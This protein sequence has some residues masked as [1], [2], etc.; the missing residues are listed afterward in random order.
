[1]TTTVRDATVED[2]TVQNATAQDVTVQVPVESMYPILAVL[3]QL[4][5]LHHVVPDWTRKS[6]VLSFALATTIPFIFAT[7]LACFAHSRHKFSVDYG[8]LHVFALLVTI[9]DARGPVDA[10]WSFFFGGPIGVGLLSLMIWAPLSSFL[11]TTVDTAFC[12]IP[13]GD[14]VCT[15]KNH[16]P[17]AALQFSLTFVTSLTFPAVFLMGHFKL[18]EAAALTYIYF[19]WTTNVQKSGDR[20]VNLQL[21]LYTFNNCAHLLYVISFFDHFQKYL[22]GAVVV[23]AFFSTFFLHFPPPTNPTDLFEWWMT[24]NRM[25]VYTIPVLLNAKTVTEYPWS[26]ALACSIHAMTFSL[27]AP[28]LW[29][30]T[31]G[32]LT[33]LLAF[34]SEDEM[35]KR[36]HELWVCLNGILCFVIAPIHAIHYGIYMVDIAET[37]NVYVVTFFVTFLIMYYLVWYANGAVIRGFWKWVCILLAVSF[38]AHVCVVTI[39]RGFL[40]I[41]TVLGVFGVLPVWTHVYREICDAY[42]DRNGPHTEMV[43]YVVR[44]L[45]DRKTAGERHLVM[46]DKTGASFPWEAATAPPPPIAPDGTT[47]TF[48]AHPHP[49][50]VTSAEVRVYRCPKF[51]CDLCSTTCP[52]ASYHCKSCKFDVCAK[53]GV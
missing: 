49:L 36:S 7:V 43:Q 37:G 21:F 45:K 13:L 40:S 19:V 32:C 41:F 20:N 9:V 14:F 27:H 42:N 31:F 11:P 53:C 4:V 6:E 46:G 2:A 5:L 26:F 10:R 48:A 35:G 30:R 23:W 28:E 22:W 47:K 25:Y 3:L 1:M 8:R 29:V 39:P 16:G 52:G 34:P 12:S 15:L 33:S 44:M 50:V 17:Q 18:S 51:S 24:F 38:V